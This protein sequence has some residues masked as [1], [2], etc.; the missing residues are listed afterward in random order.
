MYFIT[1][2][3]T[4]NSVKTTVIRSLKGHFRKILLLRM[5]EC[6]DK[7]EVYRVNLLDAVRFVHKAWERVKEK[8]IR[9]CFLHAW[10]IQEE[11]ST[12]IECSIATT[13]EDENDL[14]LSEWVRRI[15]C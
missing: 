4:H 8:I 9:N 7:K 13:E 15:D 11:V 14:P 1:V 5:I 10:I 12:E 2:I 6:I 3:M